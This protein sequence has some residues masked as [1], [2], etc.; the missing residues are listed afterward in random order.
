MATDKFTTETDFNYR[1][2][3]FHR[4]AGYAPPLTAKTI[5]I[6]D[7]NGGRQF[8]ET[9]S[10]SLSAS[11]NRI[12]K[13]KYN[14]GEQVGSGWNQNGI[15]VVTE[16]TN[17]F[18]LHFWCVAIFAVEKHF[19]ECTSGDCQQH[20]GPIYNHLRHSVWYGMPDTVHYVYLAFPFHPIPYHHSHFHSAHLSSS[21][22]L[23]TSA[24]LLL[25]SFVTIFS[26]LEIYDIVISTKSL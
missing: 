5:Q 14:Y 9:D 3:L 6:Q 22:S 20:N 24:R 21:I 19:A 18:S 23:T 2:I 15:I 16:H 1:T 17:T 12:N 10:A 25:C 4:T 11:S 8:G 7:E 13:S 26:L